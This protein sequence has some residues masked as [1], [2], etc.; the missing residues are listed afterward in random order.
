MK[1]VLLNVQKRCINERIMVHGDAI[2]LPFSISTLLVSMVVLICAFV[3]VLRSLVVV[4]VEAVVT[5]PVPAI[6][7]GVS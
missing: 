6:V 3:G 1:L 7:Y 5:S 2:Y 4:K